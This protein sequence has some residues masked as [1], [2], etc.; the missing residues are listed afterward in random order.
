MSSACSYCSSCL[1]PYS[2]LREEDTEYRGL[3][4][5]FKTFDSD[6]DLP[7]KFLPGQVRRRD[8]MRDL[9]A[10]RPL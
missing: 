4:S 7:F 2:S 5:R 9:K 8:C 1:E 3:L 6:P 10:F